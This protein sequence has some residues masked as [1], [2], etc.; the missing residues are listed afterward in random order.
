MDRHLTAISPDVK[1]TAWLETAYSLWF[2]DIH[3]ILIGKHAR[4]Q[5]VPLISS[6]LDCPFNLLKFDG[7]LLFQTKPVRSV[8]FRA[9]NHSTGW[10]DCKRKNLKEKGVNHTA[11]IERER[12]KRTPPTPSRM[13]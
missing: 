3:I 13:C 5:R 12:N 9:K 2:E 4:R 10:I 1:V 8:E 7:L 11:T 6:T